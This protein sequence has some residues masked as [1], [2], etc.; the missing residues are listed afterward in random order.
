MQCWA[1]YSLPFLELKSLESVSA[2]QD[3]EVCRAVPHQDMPSASEL[4]GAAGSPGPMPPHFPWP[5]VWVSR[6]P[7]LVFLRTPVTTLRP[8][9]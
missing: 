7:A 9:G 1:I 5:S 6:L 8:P 3:Q 4:V 2:A